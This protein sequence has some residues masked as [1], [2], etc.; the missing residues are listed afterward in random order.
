VNHWEVLSVGGD[1]LAVRQL[2]H[3][4]V[5][6]QPFTRTLFKAPIPEEHE[7][8]IVVRM[9]LYITMAAMK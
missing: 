7:S 2:A 8:V 9:I 4:H 3:P 1:V 5:K 6:E